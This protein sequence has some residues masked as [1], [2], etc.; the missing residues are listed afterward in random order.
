M[1]TIVLK[2]S[3]YGDIN[4]W[5]VEGD[6]NIKDVDKSHFECSKVSCD[7]KYEIIHRGD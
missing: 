6:F 3:V 1:P 5:E 2:C 4:K 7:G